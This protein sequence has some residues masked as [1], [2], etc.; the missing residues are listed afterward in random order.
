M[1]TRKLRI[2]AFGQAFARAKGVAPRLATYAHSGLVVA[3][4]GG[5]LWLAAALSGASTF[6]EIRPA[7]TASLGPLAAFFGGAEP[8]IILA[9]EA[10]GQVIALNDFDVAARVSGRVVSI[11]KQG[12]VVAEGDL[13]ARFDDT[14]ARSTLRAAESELASARSALAAAQTGAPVR[15]GLE[16]NLA[17]AFEAGY[18]A[19]SDAHINFA[20]ISAG[21]DNAMNGRDIKDSQPNGQAYVSLIA[22]ENPDVRP[23]RDRAAEDLERAAALY[24]RARTGYADMTRSSSPEDVEAAMDAA[25]NVLEANADALK[26]IKAFLA[27]VREGHEDAGLTIPEALSVHEQAITDAQVTTNDN[28]EGVRFAKD[29]LNAARQELSTGAVAS[30]MDSLN[31]AIADAARAVED[32]QADLGRYEVRAPIAGTIA[33]VQVPKGSAAVD[34]QILATIITQEVV[35]RVAVAEADIAS[36]H[37]GDAADVRFDGAGFTSRGT[38]LSVDTAATVGDG[39]VSFMTIIG[40]DTKDERIRQGMT[41]TARI[42]K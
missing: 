21:A 22:S 41:V 38:V 42:S 2:P 3:T 19:L 26:S 1:R 4:I 24:A 27:A 18:T 13:I 25:Y 32:A 23:L 14:A 36:V 9:V 31:R 16:G 29:N 35:A 12:D 10:P 8:A 34:G 28:I 20:W 6:A 11:A 33:D 7:L 37:Q 17:N 30:D 15:A 5:A 39:R 40:F